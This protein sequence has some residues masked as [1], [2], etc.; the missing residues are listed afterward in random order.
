MHQHHSHTTVKHTHKPSARRKLTNGILMHLHD[1]ELWASHLPRVPKGLLWSAL[2]GLALITVSLSGLV[3]DSN[4]LKFTGF[5]L[6]ILL[7][8]PAF[9]AALFALRKWRYVSRIRKELFDSIGLRGD[10]KVLDVGCGSGLLLNGAAM[11][12]TSGKATGID[13][14]SP[15]SGGGSLELLWKNAKAEGV[16]DRIEFKEADARKLGAHKFVVTSDE[17]QLKSVR[18]YFDFI[19]D[20]VSVAHDFNLYL[21]LLKTN[22]THICVGVPPDP[23]AVHAFSLIAGRKTLAGSMIGGLPETQEMLDFCAQHNIVSDIEMIDIKDINKA[24]E[25]MVKGD[26]RY[27]FVIDMATL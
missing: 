21:S 6:G 13:I 15:H 24:Y 27:R 2:L 11:R 3:S 25:R 17:A 7:V 16:A 19:L 5:G 12:L 23:A 20:T 4:L 9:L 8:L 14:W 22:G 26:V 10:E 18:G 1:T